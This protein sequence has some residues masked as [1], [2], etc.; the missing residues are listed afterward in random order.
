MFSSNQIV[1][2]KNNK[3]YGIFSKNGKKLLKQ[4]LK[5]F[6]KNNQK[7]GLISPNNLFDDKIFSLPN[8]LEF[9]NPLY[10]YLEI[11]KTAAP[12]LFFGNSK[13][14]E[15]TVA[16]T[17]LVALSFSE[18]R[19]TKKCSDNLHSNNDSNSNIEISEICKVMGQFIGH[20]LR[21]RKQEFN[22]YIK[23]LD[24]LNLKKSNFLIQN[25][26]QKKHKV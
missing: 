10:G 6:L 3:T 5:F 11:K 25:K 19:V 14:F 9:C 24:N 17:V 4:Y 13:S 2:T 7:G 18:I 15:W 21:L 8:Y 1:D 23:K 22:E 16:R 26:T 12:L 20:L